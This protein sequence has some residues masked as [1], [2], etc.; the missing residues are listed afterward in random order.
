MSNN[1]EN[2][3]SINEATVGKSDDRDFPYCIRLFHIPYNDAHTI[4]A[5]GL[6]DI[7]AYVEQHRS[8]LEQEVEALHKF[9]E[10]EAKEQ[11]QIAREWRDYRN[12]GL[13]ERG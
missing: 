2:D 8:Q 4:S 12:K 7:A 11:A 5:Q 6:L 1:F 13:G 10:S 9:Q 3:L